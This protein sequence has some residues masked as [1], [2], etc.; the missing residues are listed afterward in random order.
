MPRSHR[1]RDDRPS[2]RFDVEDNHPSRRKRKREGRPA[3]RKRT[4]PALIVGAA[5]GVFALLLVAGIAIYLLARG[6]S[7]PA[8]NDLLAHAPEDAVILSGYD[9]DQLAGTEAAHKALERRAPADLAELDKA[10][11]RVADL[12]RVLVARTPNNGNTCVIRFKSAPDRAKYLAAE[13]PGKGYAPFTS[14]TG[15]YKFGYFADGSTLVLADKEP[16][17][18]ALKEKGAKA[19]VPAELKA[20]VDKVQGPAWRVS[21]RITATDHG[22][23]GTTDDGFAIRA[24]ASA[25]TAA[26]MVPDGRLAEVRLELAY[27]NPKDAHAGA[28]TLRGLFIQQ[29]GLTNEFGLFVGRPGVDSSDFADVRRG[30]SEAVVTESGS[31]V[32]ARLVLPTSEA[33]YMIGSARF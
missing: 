9:I 25:G 32:S 11:I 17:I 19:R 31:K 6:S 2:D 12:S 10:G 5:V 7:A 23:F 14:L 16:T 22:R 21:G 30:Y 26:W 20:M 29:K 8:A 18:Q 13:L 28:A 3:A 15:N 4:S 24:G 1:N 33:L 27:D